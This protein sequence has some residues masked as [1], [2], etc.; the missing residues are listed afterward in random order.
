MTDK[1]RNKQLFKETFFSILDNGQEV[2]LPVYGL[3]MFPFYLPGDVVRVIKANE[4]NLNVGDMIVFV[5]GGKIIAHRLIK[6][7]KDKKSVLPKGDG[8]PVADR[9]MQIEEVL[10]VV[11]RH[12]RNNKE[13]KWSHSQ[14]VKKVIAF[15]SPVM[16][17]FYFYVGVV[18]NKFRR[19]R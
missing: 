16:G 14:R 9:D 11:V 2:E 8:L 10:G 6:L 17:Y 5:S 15:A 7:T 12:F 13:I 4:S 1:A 3:S 18:W 19:K